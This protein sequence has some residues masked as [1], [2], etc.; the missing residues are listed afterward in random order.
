[1]KKIK[2]LI[3]VFIIFL[4]GCQKAKDTKNLVVYSFSGE[5]DQFKVSNGVI[6]LS[7]TNDVFY[8]GDLQVT[9]EILSEITSF[10]KTFYYM[11]NNEKNTIS[12][13]SVV[14]RTGGKVHINGDLGK[15]SGNNIILG[16]KTH[17]LDDL[18]N[19]LYFE[20]V[21]LD[22]NGEQNVYDLKMSVVEITKEINKDK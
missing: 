20:L 11:A 6:V 3:F 17:Q 18:K 1:M 14:D 10:D 15:I 8:G 9:D 12:T 19:N 13:N 7:D 2:L 21:T 5:N 16:N 22:K 4:T